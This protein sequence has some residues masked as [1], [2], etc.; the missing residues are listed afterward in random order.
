MPSEHL[1]A[2][3]KE[4]ATHKKLRRVP[5]TPR[6]DRDYAHQGEN[7]CE[8]DSYP[9]RPVADCPL[10]SLWRF[11]SNLLAAGLRRLAN[12]RRAVL[13]G[14]EP[15]SST[16]RAPHLE[17]DSTY[18]GPQHEHL[19]VEQRPGLRPSAIPALKGACTRQ[20]RPRLSSLLRSHNDHRFPLRTHGVKIVPKEFEGR[21]NV[22]PWGNYQFG[23]GRKRAFTNGR[24]KD[25]ML[26][27][28]A[29]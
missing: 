23:L 6:N 8:F 29:A 13:S 10:P 18:G 11:D 17:G 1:G 16:R 3:T 4:V 27:S 15:R 2:A 24:I 20:T 7:F 21:A 26:K 28:G 9:R 12:E 5:G 19:S 14:G 25:R 22:L